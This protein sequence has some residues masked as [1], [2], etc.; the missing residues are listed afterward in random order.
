MS[1]LHITHLVLSGGGMHGV[2][3]IGALRYL[4][5]EGLLKNITHVAGTSIGSFIGLFVALKLNMDEIE[6][7]MYDIFY[8]DDFNFIPRKNY[9]KLI[10][11]LGLTSTKSITHEL[12][13]VIKSKYD[14]EDITFKELA[15]RFG[16]NMYI[17]ATNIIHC[18]NTIFSV[19]DTPD[20]SVFTAC[21]ASMSIPFLYVPVIIDN[22][23][24][25]DG[26]LSNNFPI[27]MFSNVPAENILGMVL[28]KDN[29][30]CD[31]PSKETV[32]IFFLAKQ[33]FNILNT[34][35]VKEVTYRQLDYINNLY[36]PDNIPFKNFMN[37]KVNTQGIKLEITTDDINAMI[38]AGFDSIHKYMEARLK[39]LEE[40]NKKLLDQAD[41]KDI[42]T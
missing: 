7:I 12:K 15:K 14:I 38:Y 32:N 13:K 30:P 20:L 18:T 10:S 41:S 2:M 37:F 34:F 24:Y 17:S 11:N 25:Y 6:Q 16:I 35:R 39:K 29:K 27:K 8:K 36:I 9:L 4:Y 31:E 40:Q 26:G 19:D 1:K 21:E 23:H 28:H 5:L 3:Y 33:I 42:S 22:I